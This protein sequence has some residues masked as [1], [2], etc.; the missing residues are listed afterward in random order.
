MEIP[1]LLFQKSAFQF[2]L[3]Q[4]FSGGKIATQSILKSMGGS[5]V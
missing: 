1:E 4:T 5:Q 3:F 2:F